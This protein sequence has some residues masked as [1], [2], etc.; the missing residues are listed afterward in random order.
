MKRIGKVILSLVLICG[1]GFAG[2]LLGSN[3]GAASGIDEKD[4][5][6]IGKMESL[7]QLID[8]NFL[9][10]YDEKKLYDGS[11]KGMFANLGDPFT[12]YYTPDE[13]KKLMENLDGRY[14][15]I[16]VTVSAS[17]EG[18]IKVIQVF[19]NSPAK[20]A[21]MKAGDYIIKVEGKE[22]TG[23]QLEEAVGVMKGDADT[24]VKIVVKRVDEAH[25]DGKDIEM[26][27]ERRAITV[28]TVKQR[29]LDIAGKK[30]GYLQITAFDDVTWE[31]FSKKYVELK[32]QNIDGL[33]MDLRNNPGGALDVCL[34]IADTFLDE[35]VI[36]TTEDKNKQVVTEKS[37]ANC[38][39]IPMVVLINE[40][41]ASASEILS[42]ALKDRKRA[43]IVGTKSYGK[44]IV[45]KI[46][47][48]DDGAGAKIT[49]SE[50]KT[51]NGNKINKIGVEPDVVIE[52]P[53]PEVKVI[54]GDF[55]KDKQFLQAI[56]EMLKKLK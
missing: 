32:K 13:F 47:P 49:I 26:E 3:M 50:Y 29:T 17:K 39:D 20:E 18:L 48:L 46:F 55:K 30:L 56:A 8:E 14:K 15:G 40:Y 35:G 51:P 6:L 16:G 41:S 10:D 21:G 53:T 31:D 2:Y 33:I 28:D 4:R 19:D 54:D 42:G 5:E 43:T 11:L 23:D 52:N 44:G 27:V 34:N 7:K 12:A 1:I 22:Y 36:V 9:F 38:D 37:D 25:P 24:K 45:Q